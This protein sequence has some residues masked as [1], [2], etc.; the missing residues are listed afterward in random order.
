MDEVLEKS[1]CASSE[2]ENHSISRDRLF[3]DFITTQFRTPDSENEIFE[4]SLY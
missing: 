1:D 3:F 4:I 2:I